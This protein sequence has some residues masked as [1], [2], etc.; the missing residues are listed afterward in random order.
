[1][2]PKDPDHSHRWC[3]GHTRPQK[4]LLAAVLLDFLGRQNWVTVALADM[5]PAPEPSPR[6]RRRRGTRGRGRRVVRRKA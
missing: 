1:M 3:V 2:D 5:D 6:W 4:E